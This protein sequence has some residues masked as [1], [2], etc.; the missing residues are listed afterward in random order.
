MGGLLRKEI[1]KGGVSAKIKNLLDQGK[2]TND[3]F[4]LIRKEVAS[5]QK[6]MY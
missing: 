2:F 6:H 1:D 3:I 4:K 5:A